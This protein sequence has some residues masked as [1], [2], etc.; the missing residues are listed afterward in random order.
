MNYLYIT[1]SILLV[2]NY[3]GVDLDW[4]FDSNTDRE[5]LNSLV[6]D[7]DSIFFSINPEWI[8]S[9]AIPVTNWWGRWH[10]FEFL[11]QHI[12]FLMR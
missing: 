1:L 12:D 2:N 8:I 9:M 7:M 6:S 4:N 5:N 10:D 3:D 11:E